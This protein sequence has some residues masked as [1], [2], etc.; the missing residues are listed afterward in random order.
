MAIAEVPGEPDQM[1]R[2]P[3]FDLD[4]RLGGGNDFDQSAVVEHQ[5]IATAERDRLF[6]V[7]QEFEPAGT[8]HRHPPPVP[9]IEIEYDGIG[10]GLAP[11]VLRLEVCGAHHG[12]ILGSLS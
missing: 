11:A 2:I 1:L 7:E 6:Q 3:A 4:Q 5:R 12:T 8:G 10:R 9:V